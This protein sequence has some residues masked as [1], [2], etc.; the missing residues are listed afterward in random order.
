MRETVAELKRSNAELEQFAYVVSHDLREP[1]RMVTAYAQL[2]GRRYAGQLDADGEEFLHYVTDGARR[3]ERLIDDILAF[4]RVGRCAVP[5]SGFESGDAL[6]TVLDDLRPAIAETGAEVMVGPMPAIVADRGQIERLFENLL[7][8]ALKYRDPERPL[9]I[10][11]SGEEAS[12]IWQFSVADNGI[13]IDS[14]DFDRIFM[15]FE[16]LHGREVPG[17]GLGLAICKKIV[18]RHGGRIWV[19]SALGA[20]S[21]FHLTLARR[22]P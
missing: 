14:A 19:D 8:N 22:E 20:G 16:R 5:P 3:M 17:T 13:G 18:E 10:T 6:Q 12:T 15:V 1:L 11:V 21:T 2:L 4:S 7:A 9:R